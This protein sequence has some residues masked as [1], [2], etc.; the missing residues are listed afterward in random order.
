MIFPVVKFLK[1]YYMNR[2]IV[3]KR[4]S[5]L[6]GTFFKTMSYRCNDK[7]KFDISYCLLTNFEFK[8]HL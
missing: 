5:S 7:D 8:K 6:K 4:N 2:V 3:V 1:Q